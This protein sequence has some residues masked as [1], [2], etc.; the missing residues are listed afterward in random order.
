MIMN[1]KIVKWMLFPIGGLLL[2]ALVFYGIAYVETEKRINK[3]YKVELQKLSIPNDSASYAAGK[4]IAE[5]RGC[6][7]CH[8]DNLSGGRPFLKQ[9]ESPIGV[10]YAGNLT[11]GN[12]GIQYKDGDWIR[13]LRHGLGK[14]N[15]SLW[16]MPSHEIYHISNQ[17]LGELIS[18]I[19]AQPAVDKTIPVKS[20][21][22]LGR[23]LTFMDEFP[24]LTAEKIDHGLVSKER[25][26]PTITPQYGAYLATV[27]QGCHGKNLKGAPAHEK[28]QP[29]FPDI[30][31]TGN[32][33]KWKESEFITAMRTGKLP[34]GKQLSAF[35]PWN[36]FTFTDNE[37]KAVY[38]YLQQ[39]K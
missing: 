23:F 17:E 27:C 25:V 5:N 33:G 38:L 29:A 9:D 31:S 4:H 13:A 1:R 14:N 35:M 16:L 2:L 24:L 19:K 21:K 12:G 34:D 32:P 30:S 8:G 3:V 28:L 7:G 20:I 39:L 22:P 11:N 26:E 37:L 36:Y 6:I 18:F 15:K 10:L